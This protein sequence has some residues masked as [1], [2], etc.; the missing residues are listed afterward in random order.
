MFG[1]TISTRSR[2]FVFAVV[3]LSACT[4]THQDESAVTAPQP[5]QATADQR[6]Q[7][8]NANAGSTGGVII[9]AGALPKP[10]GESI[11]MPGGGE[12][13]LH[14]VAG[15][16]FLPVEGTFND[17][18]YRAIVATSAAG[19]LTKDE[20]R[21]LLASELE[22]AIAALRQNVPA[23]QVKTVPEL[24]YFRALVP[25]ESFSQLSSVA[26]MSR[27]LLINPIVSTPFDA[28]AIP[29]PSSEA[30]NGLTVFDDARSDPEAFSGLARVGVPEFL[31]LIEAEAGSQP[32]GSGIKVGVV[33]TGVTYNHPTF[34]DGNGKSRVVYLKDFTD[35]AR[36]YFHPDARFEV[37]VPPPQTES[38]AGA[39]DESEPPLLL[40]AQFLVAPPGA[41]EDPAA[42]AFSTVRELPILVGPELRAR[43]TTRNSGARLGVLSE[44][45]YDSF[46]QPIDINRNG[47]TDDNLWVIYLPDQDPSLA[48]LY[49]DITGRGDFRGST[50]LGDF[51]LT[52]T[53]QTAFQEKFGVA[54]K[55]AALHDKDG[56]SVNVVTAAVV[57]FDPGSHGSHVSGIIAGR[58][59]FSNAPDDTLARGVAPNAQLMVDRVCANSGGCDA[60][61]ALVD[62]ALNGAA[63]VNMSIGGLS[64]FNDGYGVQETVINRATTQLNT[65]FL[66]SAGNEGPG[67]NT[68]GSP[69]VA[70]FAVSVGATAARS[71]L[72]RQYQWP[73]S[74]KVDSSNAADEDFMLFFSSRGPTAAGGFK[75]DLTAPGTE[76][77]AVPLNAPVGQREGLD[78]YWGT[79]MAA[80]VVTGAAALL[81]DAIHK[82]NAHAPATP[83]PL[84]AL[85]LRRVLTTSARPFDVSSFNTQTGETTS[86]QYTWIDQGHGMLDLP[87]AWA[88]LKQVRDF[89][90]P[91]A[92]VRTADNAIIPVELDYDVRVIARYPNGLP[93]D[94]SSLAATGP[95]TKEPR[96]GRGI[97]L[98]ASTPADLI[99]V[100]VTRRLPASLASA[101]DVAELTRQLNTTADEFTFETV[102][103]G[104][105][106]AWLTAGALN[107]ID[108]ESPATATLTVVGAGAVDL[109]VDP[110]AGGG[111]RGPRDSTL[112]VHVDRAA[113]DTLPPG[114]HG[115]LIN[116]Y[117]IVN[118]T[119]DK[120]PAFVVPV[121]VTVP[122]KTLAGLAGYTVTSHVQS[123]GVSRNYVKVPTGTQLVKVTLDVPAPTVTGSM[124]TGCAGVSLKALEGTNVAAPIEFETA[125]S[126]AVGCDSTGRPTPPAARRVTYARQK[127][128]PGIWNLHVFGQYQYTDSPYTLDVQY[129]KLT[130]TPD[131]FEG[132][133]EVLKGAIDVAVEET[134]FPFELSAENSRFQLVSQQYASKSKVAQDETVRVADSEGSEVHTY[135]ADVIMVEIATS[136]S[137]GNDIDLTIK[138]CDDVERKMCRFAAKSGSPTDEEAAQFAPQ[139]GKFYFVEVVGYTMAT[140]DGSF[141][142]TESLMLGEPDEG[143]VTGAASKTHFEFSLDASTSKLLTSER[144]TSGKY[145]VS[146]AVDLLDQEGTIIVTAPVTVHSGAG[147]RP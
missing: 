63:V 38:M 113:L 16:R 64:P 145:S 108:D 72:E 99:A 90:L 2:S 121:Y 83:L 84:D 130:A 85:T 54:I 58:K 12:V 46:G 111:S 47:K 24:G 23:L 118:G 10:N 100:Q 68:V 21:M 79:S 116:A 42:D 81:L 125:S 102:V 1:H 131:H 117:R 22:S 9:P 106:L 30:A 75:P 133:L 115:A 13:R 93:Y 107:Q 73:G 7:N 67:H 105:K 41:G 61:E 34:V 80:P 32:D 29:K 144:F 138:E 134:S 5:A 114:D 25:V 4:R 147:P 92:L 3:A 33:D 119:R 82:Y 128:N 104:S 94:G 112:Y 126:I 57:G 137:P 52:H 142:V 74:G 71:L 11:A 143:T 48:R 78:V 132:G 31:K 140:D 26:G 69:S 27:T 20:R 17:D 77:S 55:P 36:I 49:V 60:T 19:G 139:P 45:A 65:L 91:T 122:H 28:R 123:F 18:S 136:G 146:G 86:G 8:P 6:S 51:N 70:R 129:A 89:H 96:F 127:P 88:A 66:V 141:D 15:Q 14:I 39:A 109:P 110:E 59:T 95:D 35:E 37:R 44:G 97:W 103:Y 120:T 101:P 98:D 50:P 62:L 53:T 40:T 43:L 135:D 76:L 124:A 87:R 56:E